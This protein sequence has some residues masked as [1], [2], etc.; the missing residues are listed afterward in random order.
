MDDEIDLDDLVSF[1]SQVTGFQDLSKEEMVELIAPIVSIAHYEPGQFI[2][3]TGNVGHNLFFLYKGEGR[4]DVVFPSGEKGHFPLEQGELFG[5]MALV[6][7]EKRNADV[8]AVT[9][10]ICL[11]IDIETFQSVMVD[12]W[13]ITK[14]VARLIGDRRVE[15]LSA[16]N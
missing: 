15:R 8:V 7:K 1:L 3:K 10:V 16:G 11:T 9:P 6:S 12:H 13:Q 4:I 2:I 5:E 14:A